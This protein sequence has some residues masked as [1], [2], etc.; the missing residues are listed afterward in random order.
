[1]HNKNGWI[2]GIQKSKTLFVKLLGVFCM[3][4][5]PRFIY[6]FNGR[7]WKVPFDLGKVVWLDIFGAITSQK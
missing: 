7:F 2:L 4:P 3:Q 5:M 1:M 6:G